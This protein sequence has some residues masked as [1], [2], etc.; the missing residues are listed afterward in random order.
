MPS[1]FSIRL[2]LS[3]SVSAGALRQAEE[4]FTQALVD[5][6]GDAALV[7]PTWDAFARIVQRHGEQ[8]DPEQLP[9]AE[10][11]IYESWRMAEA[12]ALAAAFGPHRHMGEG[13]YE[14]VPNQE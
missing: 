2:W 4:R 9:D 13:Q 14:I 1:P 11:F 10:R 7:L 3:E 12:D 5:S 8:P 6:L